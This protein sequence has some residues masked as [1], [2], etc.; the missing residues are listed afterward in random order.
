MKKELIPS[1]LLNLDLIDSLLKSKSLNDH[2]DHII[3]GLDKL[4]SQYI[5]DKNKSNTNIIYKDS[6]FTLNSIYIFVKL[7]LNKLT[8]TCHINKSDLSQLINL[9]YNILQKY[10]HKY[11][12]YT[13]KKNIYNTNQSL[14][15]LY[16]NITGIWENDTQC[17]LIYNII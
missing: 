14:K 11:P 9:E 3:E 2:A 16:I 4:V 6:L 15:Y 10:K 17:G 7:N 12:V 13:I 5:A 1:S 8:K